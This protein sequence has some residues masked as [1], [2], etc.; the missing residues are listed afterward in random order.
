MQYDDLYEYIGHVGRI[1]WTIFIA[2][3]VV[4]MF[5]V[6]TVN[7]IFVGG[8]IDHWCSIKHLS[9]LSPEQQKYVGLFDG[10]N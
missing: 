3:L 10:D 7:V 8:K 2:L 4:A 9:N 6:D 1:Q 5:T